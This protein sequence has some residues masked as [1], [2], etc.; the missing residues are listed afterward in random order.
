MELR[1][2]RELLVWLVELGGP[3]SGAFKRGEYLVSL[4]SAEGKLPQ[5]SSRFTDWLY[6][7]RGGGLLIFDDSDAPGDVNLMR[8][9]AVTAAGEE[10]AHR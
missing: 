6:E 5:P 9:F 2:A 3:G 1:S 7:L 10:L 8:G 4:A